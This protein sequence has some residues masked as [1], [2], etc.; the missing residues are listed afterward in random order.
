[1]A[2]IFITDG[3]GTQRQAKV[4]SDNHLNVRSVSETVE[5]FANHSRGEAFSLRFSQTPTGANDCFFYFKNTGT[6]T[7]VFEGLAIYAASAEQIDIKLKDI[8]TPS[9]GST[10]TPVNLNT[11][12]AKTIDATIQQGADITGLSGGATAYRVY[13]AAA[14]ATRQ[15]NFEQDIIISPQTTLTLYAV[16]GAIAIDG[17]LNVHALSGGVG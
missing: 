10:L 15:Y 3:T 14:A 13:A 17:H 12:S 16:N 7:Y 2:C 9:G 5:H 6:K 4:N 11:S 8:G 1:M